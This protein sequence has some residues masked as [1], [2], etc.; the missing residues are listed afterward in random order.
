MC[1]TLALMLLSNSMSVRQLCE[2]PVNSST[3]VA[4]T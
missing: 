4:T 2:Q 3:I 1:T